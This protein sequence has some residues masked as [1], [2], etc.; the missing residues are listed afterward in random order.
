MSFYDVVIAPFADFAF[1][2]RAL[3]GL[4]ALALGSA[5]I[6]VFLVLRRMSLM[7]DALTHAVLPGAAIGYLVAGPSIGAMS[8]GGFAAGLLVAVIA[9]LITRFTD[10]R[11]DAGI[12]TVFLISLAAGVMIISLRGNPIDLMHI[13]FGTVLAVDDF[14]LVLVA[15]GSSVTLVL[16][17]VLYRP[18]VIECFDPGFLRASGAPSGLYHIVF[19]VLVVLN[20]VAGFQALGTLMALGMLLLPSVASLFWA[21]SVGAMIAIAWAIAIV[22]AVAGLIVSFHLGLPSGPAI[23]LVAGVLYSL[24]LLFGRYGSVRQRYFPFRHLAA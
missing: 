10:M 12:A 5:P 2:R 11:E 16:L 17:A 1:M 15:A 14:A 20:L 22:A 8:L 19:L 6:G 24:S 18:F 23:V 21:R 3:V 13:L 7:G 4:L 9:G